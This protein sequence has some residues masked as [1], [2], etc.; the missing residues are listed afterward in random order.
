MNPFLI[1][2]LIILAII[3][4]LFLITFV[5]FRIVFFYPPQGDS[6]NPKPDPLLGEDFPLI[7]KM[8]KD[9][10]QMLIKRPHEEVSVKTDDG[11][12]LYGDFYVNPIPTNNTIL[13]VH[14]YNSDAYGDFGLIGN[15]LLDNGY[16]CL[17]LNHR[18][19]AKSEGKFIGFGVLDSRDLIKWIEKINERYP[20]GKII[21]YGISMG[22]ATVMQASNKYLT[23]NVVGIVEDCGFTSCWDE[24]KHMLNSIAHIPS[25]PL[26]NIMNFYTKNILGF[27]LRESDS[28]ACL[29][30]TKLPVLFIHGESDIFVPTYMVDECYNACNS[31][32]EKY[33]YS[34]STHAQSY[35]KHKEEYE[36]RLYRFIENC[37]N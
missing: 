3:A 11:Y 10:Q 28:R 20:N 7:A 32:K 4:I 24:F 9:G 5:V 34:N 2:G 30:Q 19:H 16:N 31:K 1:V 36:E 26:L 35:Y 14:G 12:T 22:A 18:H 23:D 37:L 17:L 6:E 25:F 21:I 29:S 8:I 27:D 33:T 15:S 13:C